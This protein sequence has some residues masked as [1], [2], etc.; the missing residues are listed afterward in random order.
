[1]HAISFIVVVIGVLDVQERAP[2]PLRQI[3]SVICLGLV[4]SPRI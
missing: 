1:L 3:L 2:S 4:V